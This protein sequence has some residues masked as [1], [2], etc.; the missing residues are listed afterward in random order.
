[1]LVAINKA[2]SEFL[3]EQTNLNVVSIDKLEGIDSK[4]PVFMVDVDLMQSEYIT[5]YCA[6]KT[7]QVEI[8]YYGLSNLDILKMIETLEKIFTLDLIVLGK[9]ILIENKSASK[10]DLHVMRYTFDVKYM[11]RFSQLVDSSHNSEHV[12]QIVEVKGGK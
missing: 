5:K 9:A 7:V 6:E 11:E 2:V 4:R 8:V 1:M 10:S 3:K 12:M